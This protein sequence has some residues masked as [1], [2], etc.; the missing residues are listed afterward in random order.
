LISH[1]FIPVLV[2]D[3]FRLI[4]KLRPQIL[5]DARMRKHQKP[6]RQI[7]LAPLTI[8]LGPNF[9]AGVNV[10]LA[11]ETARGDNLGQVITRG[12][13]SPLE[14]EPIAIEG[15]ARERYLYAP[16]AGRFCTSHQIGEIVKAGQEIAHIRSTPLCAPIAGLIRGLTHDGALVELR[17]KVVEIDPRFEGAQISGIGERPARIAEGVLSAIQNWEANHVH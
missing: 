3:L 16:L 2:G 15:H 8:G 13:T 12:G 10:R 7:H 6:P 5:V 1:E 11:V 9:V 14:G 17:T 4:E